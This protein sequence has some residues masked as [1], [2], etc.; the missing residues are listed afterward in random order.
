MKVFSNIVARL[1]VSIICAIVE[2]AAT[3]SLDTVNTIP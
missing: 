3:G 1:A 2:I